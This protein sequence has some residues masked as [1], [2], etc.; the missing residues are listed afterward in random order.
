[1]HA[2]SVMYSLPKMME[3]ISYIQSTIV[4]SLFDIIDYDGNYITRLLLR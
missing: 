4:A 3:T 1:M 2:S